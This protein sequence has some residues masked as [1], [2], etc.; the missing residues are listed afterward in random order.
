[1]KWDVTFI[2]AGI[3]FYVV[4]VDFLVTHIA[5]ITALANL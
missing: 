5:H 2:T 3:V 1:M 4:T